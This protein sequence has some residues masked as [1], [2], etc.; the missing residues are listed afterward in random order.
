MNR[1]TFLKLAA[2][3]PLAFSLPIDTIDR[4]VDIIQRTPTSILSSNEKL[5]TCGMYV[6]SY[7][8]NNLPANKISF[9]SRRKSFH[10]NYDKHI[11]ISIGLTA[12]EQEY[13]KEQFL[14]HFAKPAAFSL[15]NHIKAYRGKFSFGDVLSVPDNITGGIYYFRGSNIRVLY[16]YDI[17]CLQTVLSFD[18][19]LMRVP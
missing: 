11:D 15:V 7:L 6:A 3:T 12:K 19:V 17:N 8:R 16:S 14:Q 1:R 13:D 10:P 18:T 5:N 4:G 9:Y 2:A